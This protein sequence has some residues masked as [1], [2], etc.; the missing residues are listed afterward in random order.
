M[1]SAKS[2]RAIEIFIIMASLAVSFIV[3]IV[4]GFDE[5]PAQGYRLLW[6]LPLSFV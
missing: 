3:I 6:L 4:V 5:N 1:K 2:F